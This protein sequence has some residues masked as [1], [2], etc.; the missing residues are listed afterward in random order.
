MEHK[1]ETATGPDFLLYVF[2]LMLI[3]AHAALQKKGPEHF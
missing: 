2:G 3:F 1:T